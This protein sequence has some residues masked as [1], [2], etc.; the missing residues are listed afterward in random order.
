[1][2]KRERKREMGFAAGGLYS[3]VKKLFLF[4]LCFLLL[5]TF[6]HTLSLSTPKK[7][8]EKTKIDFQMWRDLPPD[9]ANLV[10]EEL[11]APEDR[12]AFRMACRYC[13]CVCG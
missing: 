3:G 10:F 9:L 5:L 12:A 8:K 7:K 1:M 13:A 4:P 11:D 6:R 2:P